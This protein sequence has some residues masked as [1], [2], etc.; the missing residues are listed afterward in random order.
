M[1][2]EA[3]VLTPSLHLL[4]KFIEWQDD[5]VTG[6]SQHYWGFLVFYEVKEM[7]GTFHIEKISVLSSIR[8]QTFSDM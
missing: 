2:D 4:H 7:G 5:F 6:G 1:G 8:E 3:V